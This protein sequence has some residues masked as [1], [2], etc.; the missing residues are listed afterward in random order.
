MNTRMAPARNYV[1]ISSLLYSKKVWEMANYPSVL[2]LGYIETTSEVKSFEPGGKG[3]I[4]FRSL[5]I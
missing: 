3:E 2:M 5:N 4:L 1:G